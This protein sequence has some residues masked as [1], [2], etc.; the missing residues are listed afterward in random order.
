MNINQNTLISLNTLIDEIDG[1]HPYQLTLEYNTG[2]SGCTVYYDSLDI[3]V[4]DIHI[5]FKDT[6]QHH[7]TDVNVDINSVQ[8]IEHLKDGFKITTDDC[9]LGIKTL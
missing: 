5:V 2:F 4:V 3:D 7:T 8:F 6:L 9:Q 1:N